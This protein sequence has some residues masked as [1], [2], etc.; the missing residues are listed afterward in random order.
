MQ[1]IL[2]VEDDPLAMRVYREALERAGLTVRTAADGE[3]ALACLE[4]FTPDLAVVDL[5]LP[6]VHGIEVIKRIR[7]R[8]DSA[9]IPVIVLSNNFLLT[10]VK[11]AR[12]A[13]ATHCLTKADCSAEQ[14]VDLVLRT[15]GV[16]PR[17][18]TSRVHKGI[19][20]GPSTG[21]ARAPAPPT[22]SAHVPERVLD[23][24]ERVIEGG[25]RLAASLLA[26]PPMVAPETLDRDIFPALAEFHIWLRD[27]SASSYTVPGAGTKQMLA[28]IDALLNELFEN[29]EELRIPS[30][31]S[32]AHG[33][34][35]AL[36]MLAS[37]NHPTSEPENP[38]VMVVD[39][40]AISQRMVEAALRSVKLRPLCLSDSTLA[41]RVL[42]ENSFELVFLDGEMPGLSGFDLCA[43]LRSTP[44]HKLTPVVFVTAL[45]QAET[46]AR[47]LLSGANDMILKPFMFSELSLKALTCLNRAQRSGAK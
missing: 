1:R 25:R 40:E 15:L 24:T 11:L 43:R 23:K 28:G 16:E 3:L 7:A 31:R 27:L 14:L 2:M 46:R 42:E 10:M 29:T 41:L 35:T 30:L 18:A 37:P 17:A 19:Q 32:L 8:P 38:R 21:G 20:F 44:L 39:D 26:L 33:I 12:D 5:M 47:S 22:E 4:S 9:S 34:D 36:Q 6:K 45:G 13:G